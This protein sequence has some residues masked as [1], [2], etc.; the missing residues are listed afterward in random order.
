[1]VS[2]IGVLRETEVFKFLI[3]TLGLLF[4][5]EILEVTYSEVEGVGFGFLDA[6]WVLPTYSKSLT[7]RLKCLL[8]EVCFVPK[9]G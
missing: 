1:M 7:F 2:L 5:G 8:V 4:F 9:L 6:T 3:G